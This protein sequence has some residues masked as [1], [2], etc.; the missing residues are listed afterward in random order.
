MLAVNIFAVM[1]GGAVGALLRYG[2]VN[3]VIINFGI[4]DIP[5]GTLLVNVLGSFL[6]GVLAFLFVTKISNDFLRMFF[7]IG[8]LGSFTTVS[9]FS[10]ETVELLMQAQY[11]RAVANI[12]ATLVFCLTATWLGLIFA[13][14]LLNW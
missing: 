5:L 4:N 3:W 1:A 7:I 2:I 8:L 9:S 11:L 10:L 13:K 6:I 14:T 12:A